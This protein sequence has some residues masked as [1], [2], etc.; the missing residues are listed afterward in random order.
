M[1]ENNITLIIRSN[2]KRAGL[3]GEKIYKIIIKKKTDPNKINK[4][5]IKGLFNFAF[6]LVKFSKE[7][8]NFCFVFKKYNFLNFFFN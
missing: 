3:K 5:F 7:L 6:P 1:V 8:I 4:K 2:F